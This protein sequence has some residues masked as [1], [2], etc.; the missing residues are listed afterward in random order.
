MPLAFFK[1]ELHAGFSNVKDVLV[2]KSE[3][4]LFLTSCVLF[5]NMGAKEYNL[6]SQ[7]V[8]LPHSLSLS[9]QSILPSIFPKISLS[10]S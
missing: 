7:Q 2:K 8:I 6:F 9:F 4:I 5:Q 3:Y 10:V 1:L